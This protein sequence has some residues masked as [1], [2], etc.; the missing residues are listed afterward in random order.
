MRLADDE[1]ILRGAPTPCPDCERDP[2][3]RLSLSSPSGAASILS[4]CRCG[5]YSR[6]TD[7]LPGVLAAA[8]LDLLE[9]RIAATTTPEDA[10]AVL[11][12]I[13]EAAGVAR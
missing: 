6:E 1:T 5:V 10:V 4:S 3:R 2:L 11:R 8:L 13:L 12:T 9:Y 7:P